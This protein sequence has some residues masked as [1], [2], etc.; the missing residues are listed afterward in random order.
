MIRINKP[1][2]GPP[3]LS[4]PAKR[5]PKETAKIKGLYDAGQR[6]FT[7]DSGIYGTA[8]VKNKL[9]TVQR[10][11]CSFCESRI[12]HVSYGDV[13]HFRPKGGAQQTVDD[14]MSTPGYYWLAYDWGNLF[15]SCQICNQRFKKNL[16]PLAD[17]TRRARSH[18]DDLALEAPLFIHPAFDD[19]LDFIGFRDEYA[20]AVDDNPRGEAT[21][22]NLGLN[23]DELVEMRRDSLVGV[24]L[25]ARTLLLLP[26]GPVR[27]EVSDHLDQLKQPTAQYSSMNAAAI[28]AILG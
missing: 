24:T 18:H 4:D 22:K 12:T 7:F 19:P 27:E 11:K 13:E 16:F 20:Y 17:P 28:R 26:P 8:S 5:G 1:E 3:I 23:R 9:I 2:T 14:P 25:L 21:W 10:Q 15:L 6:D